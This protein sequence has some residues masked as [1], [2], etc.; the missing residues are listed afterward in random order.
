MKLRKEQN[1]N[2]CLNTI[3]GGRRRPRLGTESIHSRTSWI[4][5]VGYFFSHVFYG[6]AD[7]I[8]IAENH[9]DFGVIYT[10]NVDTISKDNYGFFIGWDDKEKHDRDRIWMDKSVFPDGYQQKISQ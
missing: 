3:S 9:Q 1:L 4:S 2:S 8:S 7:L 5:W 10:S 6:I